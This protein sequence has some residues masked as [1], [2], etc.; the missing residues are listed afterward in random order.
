MNNKHENS[1]SENYHDEMQPD[2]QPSPS[3][4]ALG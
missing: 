1:R 3:L 2:P 4:F